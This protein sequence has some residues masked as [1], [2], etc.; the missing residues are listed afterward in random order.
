MHGVVK[1][2]PGDRPER[3]AEDDGKQVHVCGGWL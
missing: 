3:I 1:I 2:A